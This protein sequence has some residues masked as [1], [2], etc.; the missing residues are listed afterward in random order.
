MVARRFPGNP[1]RR[2]NATG[3]AITD[4]TARRNKKFA[5][6]GPLR[7]RGKPTTSPVASNGVTMSQ[8]RNKGQM[9]ALQ[10]SV[11]PRTY[12]PNPNL[13]RNI[14]EEN[15]PVLASKSG[16]DRNKFLG[17]HPNINARNNEI[18]MANGYSKDAIMR[19]FNKSGGRK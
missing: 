18:K 16:A 5:P 7:E 2:G 15:H 1:L 3:F 11:N 6:V 8:S 19:K 13:K 4:N 10:R 14:F 12:V 17:N 9:G